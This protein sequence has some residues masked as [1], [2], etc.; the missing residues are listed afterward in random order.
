[1]NRARSCQ[2]RRIAAVVMLVVSPSLALSLRQRAEAQNCAQAAGEPAAG[3]KRQA[4]SRATAPLLTPPATAEER[5][6]V[7]DYWMKYWLNPT[8]ADAEVC[9]VSA[10]FG[11]PPEGVP[12]FVTY[13]RPPEDIK[14]LLVK[15]RLAYRYWESRRVA[16]YY[17][18]YRL[19]DDI[20]TLIKIMR[21]ALNDP[22]W[23]VRRQGL[24]SLEHALERVVNGPYDRDWD[25]ARRAKM[26][27]HTDD[28]ADEILD[29]V[30]TKGLT[31]DNREVVDEA[32][33]VLLRD[34][35]L[36]SAAR[37]R[38][39]DRVLTKRAVPSSHR[40]MVAE[41]RDRWAKQING[42]PAAKN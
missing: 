13:F 18:Q 29:L 11:N 37:L 42:E 27:E 5:K 8:D 35:A 16:A 12:F 22:H 17:F 40:K 30:I 39:L 1:M 10:L 7:I 38:S 26:L 34:F 14:Q 15:R 36:P 4:A 9:A 33:G 3:D 6:R 24:I 31:D 21:D 2:R 19:E 25:E 32:W 20:A 28:Y 23:E 41:L